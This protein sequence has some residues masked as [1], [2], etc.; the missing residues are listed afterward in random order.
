MEGTPHGSSGGFL[1]VPN[2]V[3][4]TANF[5]LF[6]VLAWVFLKKPAVSFFGGRRDDVAKAIR[7]AAEDRQRAEAL[8]REIGERLARVEGEM[9]EIRASARREAVA[10]Q[11]AL[12]KQA[13]EDAARIVAR[14]SA[15]MENRLRAARTELTG[16]AADLAVEIARDVLK[17]TVT[18]EDEER[19]TKEGV[20][21]LSGSKA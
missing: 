5:V 19:L 4:Q 9:E 13:E 3:W 20:R 2:L 17:K 18:P 10:E 16:F 6:L 14:T 8:A 1:G 12:S 7:K 11:A 21:Q 15:E